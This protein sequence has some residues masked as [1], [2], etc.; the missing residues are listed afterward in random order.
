MTL[1]PGCALGPYTI[2]SLLGRGGM[3]EVYRAQDPRLDR[4]IALKLLPAAWAS[5][6]ERRA[7]FEREARAAAALSH[8]NIC[9]IFDV[10]EADG[11]L[12]IAMEL[13]EGAT[14]GDCL[15]TGPAPMA[16]GE[17]LDIGIQ[18]ADAL[19]AAGEKHI[20]H[21][22]LK[23]G[24][25]VLLPRGQ[26]KVLDFGLATRALPA[27]PGAS[28]PADAEAE[29]TRAAPARL[30]EAGMV[31]GTVAY[32]SPEQALGEAVDER[33]DL[34]SFGV[35]LYEI[36]TGR[37]P[38]TGRT[39]TAV[40]DAVLHQTP[41]PIPRFNDQAPD[42]LVRLVTKLLEK[43]R[44]SRYQTAHDV[45][46]DLRRLKEDLAS[47][48]ISA[49][50][51]RVEAAA[52]GPQARPRS[53]VWSKTPVRV[54]AALVMLV[55]AGAIAWRLWP[56][57]RQTPTLSNAKSLLALPTKVSGAAVSQ[58]TDG[59]PE[60]LSSHLVG[61]PGLNTKRP[62]SS[63]EV[64]RLNGDVQKAVRA[65]DGVDLCL[66]SSITAQSGTLLLVVALEDPSSRNRLWSQTYEGTSDGY[67]ALVREAADG[68]RAALRPAAA[69]V[70]APPGQT[71]NAA[72]MH[73]LQ[74][75]RY[76]SNRYN[77]KHQPV[78][79][80]QA[81][82]AFDEALRLDPT[83]ADAAAEMAFIG[84]F[85][86]EE[87]AKPSDVA[88]EMERWSTKAVTLN[89]RNGL[90]WA[91]RALAEAS[92]ATPDVTKIREY[93]LRGATRAPR[94]AFAVNGVGFGRIGLTLGVALARE[95]CRVDPL[96][97]Y[98]PSNLAFMLF[99][100]GQSAE[101]LQVLDAG[102]RI[103]PGGNAILMIRPV[104][105]ADLQRAGPAFDALTQ[106]RTAVSAGRIGE[107]FLLSA[108]PS[109]LL[110]QGDRRGADLAL[111]KVQAFVNAPQTA[112]GLLD[113]LVPATVPALARH[114]RVND[115]LRLMQAC[116]ARGIMADYDWLVLDARLAPLRADPRFAAILAR[117]RAEFVV[118]LKD[119]DAAKS[120]GDLPAYLHQP[121]AELRLKL[122]M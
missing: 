44:A 56:A 33:S 42:A 3:G 41:V 28:Q 63:F 114:G 93:A 118:L 92:R 72:A 109:V 78:D 71:T 23:S 116:M 14:L 7:R 84:G 10:G 87:G 70:Q 38:F 25:I 21:R 86:I 100:G 11:R 69:P 43:D 29:E 53:S 40:I 76:F 35:V 112:P 47:G 12:F 61:V 8:P 119:L 37:P 68:V 115:A 26:V 74:R 75:G 16:I 27:G 49:V 60:L 89:P 62:P 34:F 79:L 88:P 106:L 65:Y 98:G 36:L 80:Q 96:Y 105:L 19:R 54:A 101:A 83:M 66:S 73:A 64:E 110:E 90:G 31:V 55:V 9:T 77:N 113:I 58:Y 20:V 57:S 22:D 50:G 30:T 13:L 17:V 121:L 117:S 48:R 107:H 32:M 18:I 81:Q 51:A 45:W 108:Q 104:V 91:A 2:T 67:L 39:S 4:D 99:E 46:T 120:R 6:P 59:V 122:G 95:V 103:E 85:K 24:N 102:D 1:A 15:A 94:S 111:Q 5:D 52:T 82:D 97:Q